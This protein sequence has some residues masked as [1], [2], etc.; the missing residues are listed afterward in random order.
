MAVTKDGQGPY[1][2]TL[3]V[4]SVI[5]AFRNA[6]PAIP[7]T[8]ENLQ[9]VGV[10]ESIAPRTLQA[11]RLLDL[12]DDDGNPTAAMHALRDADP[13]DYKSQMAEVV[14]A[15]Y[16]EVFAYRDPATSEA[17]DIAAHFRFYRP[18]SMQPRMVRL[19]YGLCQEAGI[20]GEVPVISAEGDVSVRASKTAVKQSRGSRSKGASR[21]DQPPPPPPPPPQSPTLDSVKARY[22]EVLLG[23]LE[24]TDGTFDTELADRIER[25]IGAKPS[26]D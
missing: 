4:T 22:V 5:Q 17:K 21:G 6:H 19:F 12:V 26:A 1:A 16:A 15:A 3:S 14:R 23:R 10:S 25:L 8:V 24:A 2:P 13:A 20:I 7:F 9:L 18:P 11:L